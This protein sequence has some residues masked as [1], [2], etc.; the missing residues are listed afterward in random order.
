M[1][2]A[3]AGTAVTMKATR[4]LTIERLR[5]QASVGILEHELATKQPLPA[6]RV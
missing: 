3:D 2:M 4:R 1:T 6:R 5:V